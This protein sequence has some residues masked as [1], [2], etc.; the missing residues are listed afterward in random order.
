MSFNAPKEVIHTMRFKL[1]TAS[2]G[3]TY[4]EIQAAGNFATLA[5]S[6]TYKSKADA[7]AAI[8]LIKSGAASASIVDNT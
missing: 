6:E 3:Q 2:N 8:D 7:L 4:F 1:T 5:T